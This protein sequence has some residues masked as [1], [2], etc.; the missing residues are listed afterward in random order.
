VDWIPDL[1]YDII[2]QAYH[3]RGFSFIRVL[4]RC[5]NYLPKLFDPWVKDPQQTLLLSHKN[6]LQ[7]SADHARIYPYE[8]HDPSDI[9]RAREIASMTDRAPV[10]I[11]Y[12]DDEVPCYE[13]I[14]AA[15]DIYTADKIEKAFNRE[16]DKF[17]VQPVG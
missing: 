9:H 13:D 16:L 3:H 8:M 12:R 10:G 11:L 14:R 15:D 1:F 17:T 7:V 4:Q 6:G 2:S 5:P